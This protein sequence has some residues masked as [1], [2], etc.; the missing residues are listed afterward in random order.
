MDRTGAILG[1]EPINPPGGRAYQL[2]YALIADQISH[3]SET[4]LCVPKVDFATMG[5]DDLN[6]PT[7]VDSA[8]NLQIITSRAGLQSDSFGNVN[9]VNALCKLIIEEIKNHQSFA[10]ISP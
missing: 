1:R 4:T 8:L 7:D 3:R 2:R 9:L 5:A 10:G 6:A